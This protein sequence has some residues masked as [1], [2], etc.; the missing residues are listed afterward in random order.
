MQTTS[1][2]LVVINRTSKGHG[3]INKHSKITV[4]PHA[5]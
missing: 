4:L 3:D 2:Q 5:W 1:Q